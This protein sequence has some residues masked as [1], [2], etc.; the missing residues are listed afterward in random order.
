MQS[1]SNLFNQ[2]LSVD[3]QV[4]IVVYLVFTA[5]SVT[6]LT[7]Q[8]K[9]RLLL[10]VHYEDLIELTKEAISFIYGLTCELV[11]YLLSIFIACS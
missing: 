1:L 5:T 4:S 10:F 7:I 6:L 9:L 11:V 3:I 8:P 2:T